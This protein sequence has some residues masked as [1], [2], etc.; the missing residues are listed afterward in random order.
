MDRFTSMGFTSMAVFA[1][2]VEAGSFSAAGEA[3]SM[4]SQLVGK[5]IRMLE[6]RLGVQLPNRTTRRQSLTDAG[7]SFHERVQHILA[8][9]EAAE[10]LAEESRAT[11]AAGS[12]S[13]PRSRSA[14]TS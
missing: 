14:R 10:A 3:L 4:S 8:A 12:A 5:H 11:P 1:K 6:E 9:V 13:T 7:R 2:A